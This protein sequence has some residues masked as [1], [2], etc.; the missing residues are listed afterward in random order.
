M[1]APG[2]PALDWKAVTAFA[3]VFIIVASTTGGGTYALLSDQER[4]PA[5]LNIEP[6]V[7]SE[8]A[9]VHSEMCSEGTGSVETP[10]TDLSVLTSETLSEQRDC[11]RIT[12]L[13]NNST[14]NT[15]TSDSADSNDTVLMRHNGTGWQ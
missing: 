11:A 7:E 2:T 12:V 4:V 13:V 5:S 14:F 3:A 6:D 10:E 15:Y 8:I 9:S 1:S